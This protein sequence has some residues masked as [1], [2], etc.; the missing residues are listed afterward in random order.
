MNSDEF[1]A[2]WTEWQAG[3]LDGETAA[4]MAA[5]LEAS[6]ECRRY[7]RQMRRLLDGLARLP[8]PDELPAEPRAAPAPRR[9]ARPALW[10]AAAAMLVL[11]FG[12]GVL[13]QTLLEGGGGPDGPIVA[14]AVEVEPG[15]VRE[16]QL[17]VSA[18]RRLDDVEFVVELPPGVELEGYPGQ[19]VVRWQGR[20]VEG[21]SRLTLP[22]RVGDAAADAALITRIRH[23][24]GERE[25]R[26]PLR[27]VEAGNG[28]A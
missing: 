17:A 6:A 5:Q 20:L 26:V 7:D 1:R 4:R 14:E 19:R 8:L 3:R 15:G 16:I 23:A 2:N 10:F 21:R 12:A 9:S 25:L 13:T 11:A 28:A 24:G 22:L 18:P 27:A